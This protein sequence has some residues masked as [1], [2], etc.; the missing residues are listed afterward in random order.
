MMKLKAYNI[1]FCLLLIAQFAQAQYR[2]S[3]QITDYTTHKPVSHAE[4]YNKSTKKISAVN[5]GGKFIL[6]NLPEGEYQLVVF[7]YQYQTLDTTISLY[8]NKDIQIG[9]RQLSQELSE[10]V[11]QQQREEVFSISRL[12]PVEGT[13]IYAGKKTEVVLLDQTVGNLAANNARQIYSQVVGLN[14]YE[15]GDAGL[16][17]SIGGRGL[18]PNRSSN[19]NTRQNGYDISAD[20]LGYP[21]S[22]Y[23]PPAEALSEIQVIRGAASLQYGTQFG[24]LV[25]FV[26]KQAPTNKKL[27]WTSRQ[28]VGSYG[29][30]TSFNSLGG[31]LGRFS[32][33]T[34][35]HYKQGE[36]FRPNSAYDSK[37]LY[38][39]LDYNINESSK[40]S[41]ETTYLNYLA[42]QAGG[43]TDAQ[44]AIDPDYS[45]RSRNWFAV[46]WKLW[47]LKFKHK[48]SSSTDFSFNLFG[49]DAARKAVGF[50]GDAT[51]LNINPVSAIDEVDDRGNF[52]NPRDLMVDEF[53]N[54]GAEAR[55]LT[56]YELLNKSAVFLIGSKYYQANNS[57]M[58]GPGTNKTDA[59][60][61][62]A[63]DRF[64][65]YANQSGFTYPNRNLAI[66]G[67]HILFVSDRFSIT[68]GIRWE[69]IRTETE[70]TY[71]QVNYD[72]AGNPISNQKLDDNRSLNRSFVL[73]GLGASYEPFQN[74]EAY[75]NISQNYRSVTFSNIRTVN[76]SFVVDPNISDEKGFT[77]DLGLRGKLKSQISY[78]F[79]AFGLL[80]ND[81]IGI[82]FN[83]RAERVRKN[84]GQA[85]IY[86][87]E[88][89]ADWNMAETFYMN[90]KRY[91]L[92][93][94]INTAFTDSEYLKSEE[95]NVAGKKVEFI[96]SIN[97]KTGVRAGYKNLLANLQLTHLSKQY[98]DVENS[99]IPQAGDIRGGII[100]EIP[101]YTVL[102]VSASYALN[103]WKL[104]A[105]I[106]NVLNERY[107]TRRATGYP[108]PGIIP[109]EP[110]SFYTTLQ[111]KLDVD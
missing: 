33:Y 44:F 55:L 13:S 73:L 100:G 69:H 20:V 41:L 57:A 61:S 76:P 27:S 79:S 46:D 34:Y 86:G 51:K 95:N 16:Q 60:F 102:D 52:I 111:F 38:I 26:M 39:H 84:I 4:I 56:R 11:I 72:N 71:Q 97:L 22:Y 96:P 30:L 40:L 64:P 81:K 28:S 77:A 48:F 42:Q 12:R 18:D 94:F 93:Y 9:L 108:G 8:A 21:E 92:R 89:F 2:L 110:R 85:F 17:L 47:A 3:G 31:N 90:T 66:F 70:G 32:Y 87:V 65:N 23:T 53:N 37:N 15:S 63:T 14:I 67:E 50:R 43:L 83:D 80:Y 35:F 74:L 107:F 68:P 54:W 104:E 109:S 91:Q 25:N 58:Q 10:V 98:T 6:D 88:V 19:F 36:G 99:E 82:V 106:N 103:R 5:Q 45:N 59:D 29:L 49:L 105:G 24:G 101:A 75:A 7:S 78:D 62:F 1:S